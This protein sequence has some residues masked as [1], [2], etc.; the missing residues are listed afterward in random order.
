M[1]SRED[2]EE[3]K[4]LRDL[5]HGVV[6]RAESREHERA[7]DLLTANQKLDER[8][9]SGGIEPFE[10]REIEKHL[11]R[12]LFA[13]MLIETRDSFQGEAAGES[14][15]AESG[16]TRSVVFFDSQFVVGHGARFYG[17]IVTGM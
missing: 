16:R 2:L 13:K 6:P 17:G 9:N 1:R 10:I 11:R 8:A 3:R 12:R 15:G 7:A 5:Q 14:D 4:D